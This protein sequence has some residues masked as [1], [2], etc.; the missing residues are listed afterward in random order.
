MINKKKWVP[1]YN[2]VFHL[3]KGGLLTI[4]GTPDFSTMDMIKTF[5]MIYL[6]AKWKKLKRPVKYRVDMGLPTLTDEVA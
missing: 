6:H 4:Q 5:K 1:A 3:A 2:C